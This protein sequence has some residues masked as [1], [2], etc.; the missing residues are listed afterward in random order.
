M[1]NG[2]RIYTETD[3]PHASRPLLS[4]I[5][6]HSGFV[7]NCLGALA[8]SPVALL[9]YLSLDNQIARSR[10]SEEEKG[11]IY[12]A[13]TRENACPYCVAAHSAM[14]KMSGIDNTVVQAIREGRPLAE[15]KLETLHR[16][17]AKLVRARGEVDEADVQAMLDVGYEREQLLE[18]ILFIAIKAIGAHANRLMG[19]DLDEMLL[20]EKWS[21]VA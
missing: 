17:S 18:I 10:F 9:G 16:F 8:S 21:R 11:V 20:P 12:L 7:P 1:R 4:S 3:A 2:Y 15:R 5:R 6:E 14:A 19:T 13:I